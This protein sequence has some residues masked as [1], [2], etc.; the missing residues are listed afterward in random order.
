MKNLIKTY[1]AVIL[2]TIFWAFSFI[3]FKIANE[4]FRPLSIV[5]MRLLISM[6]LLTLFLAITRRFEKIR[7]EDRKYF[8]LLAF[9]EPF[10]YF[11][12]ESFGLT[13]V[14]STVGSVLISTIPVF[15]GIGAWIFY[16]EKLK[17]LNYIGIIISFA[18]VLVFILNRDGS[19][20]IDPRGIG[21]LFLAVVS[22]VGYTL[23]LKK[24]AGTYNPIYIVNVQNIIGTLLFLPFFIIFEVEHL[25][26]VEF[27]PRSFVAVIELAV[28]ASSGAFIFFGFAVR[29]LGVTRS[30]VFSNLI[31]ILTAVF[32]YFMIDEILTIQ[33]ALGMI[34]VITGLFLSQAKKQ[35]K[36][37]DGTILAGKTA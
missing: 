24:L 7:K 29:K 16:K 5:F 35:G 37:P 32:A 15:A 34:I 33:K 9:C 13:F 28:F 3:W 25:S 6:V 27:N 22:A 1:G 4:A 20:T 8:L 2:A 23:T 10:V 31:P 21:L 12:G 18:G 30:S 19:L 17:A 36:R 11:L 14:S 26:S